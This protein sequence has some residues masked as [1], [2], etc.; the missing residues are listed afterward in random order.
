MGNN[1]VDS[2]ALAGLFGA[3]SFDR[4]GQG[5]VNGAAMEGVLAA[6]ESSVSNLCWYFDRKNSS[7][8]VHPGANPANEPSYGPYAP[9][10]STSAS[11]ATW[12]AVLERELISVRAAVD[13]ATNLADEPTTT[14]HGLQSSS[15]QRRQ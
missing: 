10:A 14:A 6:L 2:A 9:T 15:F 13:A 12:A 11:E 1:G 8:F 3:P 7:D 4:N 5:P